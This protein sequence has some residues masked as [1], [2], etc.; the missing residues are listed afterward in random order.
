MGRIVPDPASVILLR[1][2]ASSMRVPEK[3]AARPVRP[4]RRYVETYRCQRVRIASKASRSTASSGRDRRSSDR[5]LRERGADRRRSPLASGSKHTESSPGRE[6]IT[7]S[8]E[9]YSSRPTRAPPQPRG[10]GRR[11]LVV[12]Q[13]SD[14]AAMPGTPASGSRLHRG[15]LRRLPSKVPRCVMRPCGRFAR[16]TMPRAASCPLQLPRIGASS[17]FFSPAAGSAE[18]HGPILLPVRPSLACPAH[19][20]RGRRCATER[21]S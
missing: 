16:S 14:S 21:S 12:L 15:M 20:R 4:I 2:C 18:M 19:T 7:P 11:S 8:H 10:R 13:G 17:A 6:R 9:L 1:A 3:F 5:L